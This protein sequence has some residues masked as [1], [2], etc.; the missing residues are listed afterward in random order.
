MVND[1]EADLDATFTA[2]ADPTR[3]AILRRLER[4]PA[5]VGELAE[6][7]EISAPAVSKHLRMLERARL[8][9]RTR[10][11]RAHRIELTAG[12]LAEAMRW[13]ERHRSFWEPRL[14]A[15]GRHV[16]GQE[17]RKEPR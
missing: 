16:E 2:L 4:G 5:T 7:F 10:E 6:P 3:R 9:G 8:L 12:P 17:T 11:G 1:N 13:L 14:D 15:L